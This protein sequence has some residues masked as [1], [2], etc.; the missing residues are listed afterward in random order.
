MS[1]DEGVGVGGGQFVAVSEG[2]Q[3]GGELHAYRMHPSRIHAFLFHPCLYSHFQPSNID[4]ICTIDCYW[5]P[6]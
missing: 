3:V 1:D 5:W 2:E 4:H 6:R